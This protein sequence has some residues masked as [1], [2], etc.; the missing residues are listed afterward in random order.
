MKHL[1]WLSPLATIV[2]AAWGCA[3]YAGVPSP[4]PGSLERPICS[5]GAPAQRLYLR[6]LRTESGAAVETQREDPIM[7][8]AGHLLDPYIL[9]REGLPFWAGLWKDDVAAPPAERPLRIYMDLYRPGCTDDVA[10]PGFKLVA[11]GAG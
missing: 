4:G 9:R 3:T 6:R 7:G 1:L 11:P 10:P 5:D 8:P 2:V